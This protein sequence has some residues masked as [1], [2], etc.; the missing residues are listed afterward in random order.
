MGV[1]TEQLVAI[2]TVAFI[3]VAIAFS[4]SWA[5]NHRNRSRCSSWNIR[6][7]GTF[8][9]ETDDGTVQFRFKDIELIEA[10]YDENNSHTIVS[11]GDLQRMVWIDFPNETQAP[12]FVALMEEQF[13]RAKN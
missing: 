1:L 11:V 13:A 8:E 5:G 3:L 6:T 2:I 7:D 9:A 12:Q 4:F 10:S